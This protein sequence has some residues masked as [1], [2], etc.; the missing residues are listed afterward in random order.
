MRPW[1]RPPAFRRPGCQFRE[2]LVQYKSAATVDEDGG[3]RGKLH[4]ARAVLSVIPWPLCGLFL[5][6]SRPFRALHVGEPAAASSR[7][8]VEKRIT[9]LVGK[10]P[11]SPILIRFPIPTDNAFA[12]Y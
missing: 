8:A 6:N 2:I 9:S 5:H 10:R 4:Q 11:G 3:R 1:G 7:R 12:R